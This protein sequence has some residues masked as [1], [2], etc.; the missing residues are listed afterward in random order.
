MVELSE[1]ASLLRYRWSDHSGGVSALAG[2]ACGARATSRKPQ[3]CDGRHS[4]ACGFHVMFA[5][6]KGWLDE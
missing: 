4:I 2:Y 5:H 6:G 1:R 3:I